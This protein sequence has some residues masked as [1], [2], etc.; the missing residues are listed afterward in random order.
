MSIL[1]WMIT[2][3]LMVGMT[4]ATV[5]CENNTNPPPVE[6]ADA[7]EIQM[8]AGET[9]DAPADDTKV[10]VDVDAPPADAPAES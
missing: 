8:P 9:T 1:K 5:G 6:N 3:S 10:D 4:F 7:P 2:A